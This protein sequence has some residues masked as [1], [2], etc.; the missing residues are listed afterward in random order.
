MRLVIRWV[1]T[2]VSLGAAVWL[3]PGIQI[4][5]SGAVLAIGAMALILAIINVLV[6]AVL[7]FLSCGCFNL[8]MGL[9]MLV[10]NAAALWLLARFAADLGIGFYVDGY[11]AAFLGGLIVTG[12]SLLLSLLL[13]TKRA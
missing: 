8:T 6:Q 13:P 11:W 5:G 12:V 9:L 1:F 7:S 3:V 10:V 2:A 4:D